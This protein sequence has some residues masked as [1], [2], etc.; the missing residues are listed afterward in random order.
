MRRTH[1][2]CDRVSTITDTHRIAIWKARMTT[3]STINLIAPVRFSH[4]RYKVDSSL[5]LTDTPFIRIGGS[6]PGGILAVLEQATATILRAT[7]KP[8]TRDT[9]M[10]RIPQNT[11][12]TQRELQKIVSDLVERLQPWSDAYMA[13]T[14][15]PIIDAEG[16]KSVE[17]PDTSRPSCNS[18]VCNTPLVVICD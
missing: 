14:C 7:L 11:G 9:S 13:N 6:D 2:R 18:D 3:T 10:S 12:P 5:T 8:Q 1:P 15:P 16:S 17:E 4:D